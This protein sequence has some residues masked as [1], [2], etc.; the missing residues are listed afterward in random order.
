MWFCRDLITLLKKGYWPNPETQ[1]CIHLWTIVNY[2]VS[3]TDIRLISLPWQSFIAYSEDIS[4]VD[5]YSTKHSVKTIQFVLKTELQLYK[6]KNIHNI[7]KRK[8]KKAWCGITFN[9]FKI[10]HYQIPTCYS[11]K[12]HESNCMDLNDNGNCIVEEPVARSLCQDL[13]KKCTLIQEKL[14]PQTIHNLYFR[15]QHTCH[16]RDEFV[17]L[18]N[19]KRLQLEFSKQSLCH[20]WITTRNECPVISDLAIHK[21]LAFCTPYLLE[22]ALS[23]LMII[24]SKNRSFFKMLGISFVLRCHV[25]IYEWMICVKIKCS[26]PFSCAW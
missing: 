11:Q 18:L 14:D 9:Y 3:I 2:V 5:E 25:S 17:E 24:K 20:I 1:N 23:K 26:H 15:R 4:W 13:S 8:S 6:N 10:N 12:G 16:V 19:D 21:L 22:A 7:L